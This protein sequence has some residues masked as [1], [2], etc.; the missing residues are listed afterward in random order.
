MTTPATPTPNTPNELAAKVAEKIRIDF[1]GDY[2][3]IY[4]HQDHTCLTALI[5]AEL[6]PVFEERNQI[7]A[8]RNIHA[9]R[10]DIYL[11]RLVAAEKSMQAA[12]PSYDSDNTPLN[13][14]I[15]QLRA[16]IAAELER[17]QFAGAVAKAGEPMAYAALAEE[18]ATL[19]AR[20]AEL[21]SER[22]HWRVSSVCRE[23]K[24]QLDKCATQLAHSEDLRQKAEKEAKSWEEVANAHLRDATKLDADCNR[25][26]GMEQAAREAEAKALSELARLNGQTKWQCT[27]GGFVCE[28]QK[29]LEA[30]K[31]ELAEARRDAGMVDW[32]SKNSRAFSFRFIDD[33]SMC[34]KYPCWSFWTPSAGR[35]TART[36]RE[37]IEIVWTDVASIDSARSAAKEGQ[38]Q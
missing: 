35:T 26:S 22:E 15:D 25:L 8:D 1:F 4:T 17:D 14:G 30:C 21:E 23:L 6:E 29:E 31:A 27:C 34:G 38:T 7:E 16:L 37:A 10:E 24:A 12:L 32:F 28:G 20:V 5:A 2:D 11:R 33:V 19:R 13:E 36:L 3:S 18:N 9:W